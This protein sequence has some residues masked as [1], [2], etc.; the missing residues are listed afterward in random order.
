MSKWNLNETCG[1]K[2][3]IRGCLGCAYSWRRRK[4]SMPEERMSVCGAVSSIWLTCVIIFF[5]VCYEDGKIPFDSAFD[6]DFRIIIKRSCFSHTL[7]LS[8][9]SKLVSIIFLEFK[10]LIPRRMS[11]KWST[12]CTNVF[13]L[14]SGNG[15]WRW[16]VFP[17]LI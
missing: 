9:R 7:L 2:S 4:S 16:D 12:A 3:F 6:I 15:Q 5:R 1:S 13:R 11:I 10:I 14:W 17:M 8:I